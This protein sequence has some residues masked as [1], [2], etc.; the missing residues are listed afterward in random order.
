MLFSVHDALE[1]AEIPDG[2]DFQLQV[3]PSI[4]RMELKSGIDPQ[5]RS[6]I[7]AR[8]VMFLHADQIKD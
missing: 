7:F 1:A 4:F 3:D 6:H 2:R 8:A 5:G